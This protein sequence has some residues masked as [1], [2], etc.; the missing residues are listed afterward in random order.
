MR[1]QHPSLLSLTSDR[2]V[3]DQALF[4]AAPP[5][6][7]LTHIMTLVLQLYGGD[8]VVQDPAVGGLLKGE[9]S[10]KAVGVEVHAPAVRLLGLA[11]LVLQ[12]LGVKAVPLQLLV[13]VIVSAAVQGHLLLLQG[14]LR[15]LNVHTETLRDG[16]ED[17]EEDRRGG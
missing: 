6:L 11:L 15:G 5:A 9:L 12:G 3:S 1:L 2:D 7:N 14:I 17:T 13:G 10:I 8:G 16:F 4:F